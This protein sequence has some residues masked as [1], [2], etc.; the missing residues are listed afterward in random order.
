M[1]RIVGEHP[2]LVILD[3]MLPG[4]DGLDVCRCVRSVYSGPILMLTAREE[5]MDEVATG[6]RCR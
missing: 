4:M 6:G 1:K 2:D 5:D 3:L